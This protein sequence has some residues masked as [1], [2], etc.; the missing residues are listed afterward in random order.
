LGEERAT[1]RCGIRPTLLRRAL[2]PVVVMA[3]VIGVA[4]CGGEERQDVGEPSGEYPVEV[5]ESAFPTRQRLAQT[6]DFRLAVENVGE[7]AVPDLAVT[8]W[9][10]DDKARLP[11]GIRS[12]QPGLT[13]PVR[14]VW[15]LEHEYPKLLG[16]G[17]ARGDLDDEPTAGADAAQT[18]TFSF[19]TVPP[20]ESKEIV[21]RVT[22]VMAGTFTVHYEIAAGLHGNARAITADGSPVE[23]RFV[24]T[25]SDRPPQARV[26][27]D[28][29]VVIPD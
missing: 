14:P 3:L 6:R 5:T 19:G 20:G 18:G 26:G 10:G 25:I 21:W 22:P 29:Q 7:E 24:V 8:I 28:G 9:V 2:A 12:D 15:I 1:R 13:D 16:P 4:A 17:V 27:D 23:G 11:F